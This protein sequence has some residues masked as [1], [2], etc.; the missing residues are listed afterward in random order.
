MPG[1]GP[2]ARRRGDRGEQLSSTGGTSGGRA[3][4]AGAGR[5]GSWP[6][7]CLTSGGTPISSSL[8]TLGGDLAVSVRLIGMRDGPGW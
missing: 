8:T 4:V 1:G 6:R 3:A 5:A 7:R 2:S